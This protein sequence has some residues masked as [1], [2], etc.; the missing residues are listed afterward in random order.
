M[1]L[2]YRTNINH[3]AIGSWHTMDLNGSCGSE[4]TQDRPSIGVVDGRTAGLGAVTDT[5]RFQ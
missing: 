4:R 5:T 2:R 3:G 1:Y